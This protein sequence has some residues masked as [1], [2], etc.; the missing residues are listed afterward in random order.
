MVTVFEKMTAAR[1][2]R[3]NS[4][5]KKTVTNCEGIASGR[6]QHKVWKPG[7]VQKKNIATNDQLQNKVW[8]QGGQD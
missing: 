8:D 5:K 2:Q 4:D 7:G 3:N 6:M 1:K